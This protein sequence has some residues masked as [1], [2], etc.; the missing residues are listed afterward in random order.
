MHSSEIT[1]A[2]EEK[3]YFFIGAMLYE[4]IVQRRNERDTNRL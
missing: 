2:R 3:K 4:Y 1:I